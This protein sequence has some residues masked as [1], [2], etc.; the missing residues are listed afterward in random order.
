MTVG[1]DDR[2][3]LDAC[4]DQTTTERSFRAACR[5]SR[6]SLPTAR[7][8][9][10]TTVSIGSDHPTDG[11]SVRALRLPPL[12]CRAVA[13]P[14]RKDP[15]VTKGHRSGTYSDSNVDR[16]AGMACCLAAAMDNG[17]GL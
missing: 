14:P 15:G 10:R 16:F 4:A 3:R 9:G 8:K 13:W 2:E 1:D 5:H 7:H 12:L 11:T 6:K 17:V